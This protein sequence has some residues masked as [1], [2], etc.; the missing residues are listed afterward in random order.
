MD[1]YAATQPDLETPIR[2]LIA[3]LEAA[4]PLAREATDLRNDVDAIR[5][6]LDS[7]RASVERLECEL[8]ARPPPGPSFLERTRGAL[9]RP[10]TGG[11]LIALLI[12]AVG[13]SLAVLW[14]LHRVGWV[15][16]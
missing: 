8:G 1:E 5:A 6:D 2:E 7:L 11:D 15:R 12:A 3:R 16:G 4:L 9:S 14:L 13:T 10:L